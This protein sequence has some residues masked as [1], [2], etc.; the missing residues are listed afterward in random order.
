M[1][2]GGF[3]PQP[4]ARLVLLQQQQAI[5]FGRATSFRARQH[6]ALVK[7]RAAS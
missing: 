6:G 4:M 5:L 7:E 2:L 1:S 3:N